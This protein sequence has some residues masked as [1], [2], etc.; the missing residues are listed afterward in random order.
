MNFVTIIKGFSG[1]WYV[2]T[3][4]RVVV[5]IRD[6]RKEAIRLGHIIAEKVYLELIR[7]CPDN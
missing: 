5:G 3:E 7:E 1:K 2:L 6:T 4:E